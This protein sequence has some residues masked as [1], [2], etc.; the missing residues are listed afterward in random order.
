MPRQNYVIALPKPE[1]DWNAIQKNIPSLKN[2]IS[3]GP[4]FERLFQPGEFKALRLSP[5]MIR[6]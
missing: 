4:D 5:T 6:L 1:I 3:L 2:V